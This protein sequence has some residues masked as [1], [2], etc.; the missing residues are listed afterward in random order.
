M[1][2]STDRQIGVGRSVVCIK[3]DYDLQGLF[4]SSK[5]PE[6]GTPIDASTFMTDVPVYSLP[7]TTTQATGPFK[8]IA[9]LS[10]SII[11]TVIILLLVFFLLS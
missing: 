9:I 1:N 2:Q 7:L 8:R 10:A 5:C 6:C 11:I 3:C 4:A